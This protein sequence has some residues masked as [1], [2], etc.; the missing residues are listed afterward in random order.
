[1]VTSPVAPIG[2]V[3]KM[4]EG[5]VPSALYREQHAVSGGGGV[6]RL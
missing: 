3:T 6:I 4:G 1:M 2:Q 5:S